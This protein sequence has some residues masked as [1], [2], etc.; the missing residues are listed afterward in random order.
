MVKHRHGDGRDHGNLLAVV[1]EDEHHVKVLEAELDTFKVDKFNIFQGGDEG[2]PRG[3]VNL[4]QKYL[5]YL[6]EAEFKT[7]QAAGCWLQ[8]TGLA[9]GHPLNLR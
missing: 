1:L 4:W 7:H 5:V 8:Q 9:M 2:W 6:V 3:K